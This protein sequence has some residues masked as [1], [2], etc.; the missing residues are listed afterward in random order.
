MD[1]VYDLLTAVDKVAHITDLPIE[2][3]GGLDFPATLTHGFDVRTKNL[4]YKYSASG[5]YALKGIDL[6]IKSGE[7]ICI[8]GQGNSGKTTLMNIL[9]GLYADYEGVVTINNY[10][11]RDLDLTHMRDQVA[12]NISQEDIFDGT[13]LENITLGRS[14]T[15]IQDA[16]EAINLVGLSDEVNALPKGLD[17]PIISGGKGLTKT[18]I[19][20]IILARCMAKKP[21]L[22][23]LNDFFVTLA[24][25]DKLNLLRCVTNTQKAC[26]VIIVSKDP[27]VM[28]ACDRIIIMEDG[29]IR[30]EGTMEELTKMEIIKDM[31]L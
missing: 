19:H 22:L 26:T 1:V 11:L 3:V 5:Y 25:S 23:I 29:M 8:T 27:I 24:K 2:K 13:L 16:I 4:K 9:S 21:R 6:E 17:T 30:A 15:T 28:Y 7:T 18:M 31:I 10:S 14:T 12:K 20:K